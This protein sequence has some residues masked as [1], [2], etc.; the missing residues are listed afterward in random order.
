MKFLA[1]SCIKLIPF[2]LKHYYPMPEKG[3]Q[4]L[5]ATS[6][7]PLPHNVRTRLL[8]SGALDTLAVTHTHSYIQMLKKESSCNFS[9]TNKMKHG[10]T[11]P[12][13]HRL[14]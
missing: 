10:L 9:D 3:D 2:S 4:I 12:I 6:Q 14:T 7:N 5:S 8:A 13:N 1:V 11:K